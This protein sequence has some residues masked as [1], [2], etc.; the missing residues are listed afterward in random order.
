MSPAEWRA[1][2]EAFMD[3]RLSA[4]AFVRRFLEARTAAL[5][6]GARLPGAIETL[7]HIVDEYV[8]GQQAANEY[9]PDETQ[10]RQGAR[11]ALAELREDGAAPTRTYDRAR[12]R[13]DMRR[14]Q[15]RVNQ[16]A[17]VGCLIALAWLALCALQWFAVA[18]QIRSYLGWS[19][20]PAAVIGFVLAFIP[21]VGNVIAFFGA[22]DVWE[23]PVWAAA[24]VFFAAPAA[25]FL[26]G[27]HRWRTWRRR[28]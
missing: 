22:K 15:I 9:E 19:T 7:H 27:W 24:V 26:S 21:I 25:T 12:A 23:W 17:G 4:E 13:E 16:L 20:A 10:L 11:I 5:R 14:F 6:A 18:D 2:I 28:R 1:L 8:S 3:G